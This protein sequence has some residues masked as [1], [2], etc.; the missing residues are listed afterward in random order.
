[1]NDK[2][3]SDLPPKE[4]EEIVKRRIKET[5]MLQQHAFKTMDPIALAACELDAQARIMGVHM[6]Y[7]EDLED[8]EI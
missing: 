5:R 2:R 7:Q 6:E 8:E 3:L 1:M 4:Q